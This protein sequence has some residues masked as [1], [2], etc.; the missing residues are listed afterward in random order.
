MFINIL[1]E[2]YYF[3]EYKIIGCFAYKYLI[4]VDWKLKWNWFYPRCFGKNSDGL[5]LSRFRWK[6]LINKFRSF[7]VKNRKNESKNKRII[8][9]CKLFI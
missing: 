7:Y 8:N 3:K 6:I 1:N 4:I 5:E 2:R 9:G